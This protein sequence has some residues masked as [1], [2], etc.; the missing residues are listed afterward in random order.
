[1]SYTAVPT[2]APGD[3]VTATEFNAWVGANFAAG[4]PDIFTTKGDLAVA[5]AAD[6]AA[7]LAVGT[8]GYV[9]IADSAQATGVKWGVP[10]ICAAR[11]KNN[12]TQEIASG[13]ATD[14]IVQYDASVFDSD[15]AVTTGASW[16]FTVPTGKGGYYI[17]SASAT[18]TSTSGWGVGEKAYLRLYKNNSADA[19]LCVRNMNTNGTFSV[20][21]GGAA[22][23]SLAAGDYI[24]V[25]IYQDNDAAI[26]ITNDGDSN[27]IA[28]A[29]LF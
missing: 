2:Q 14:E 23:I 21:L 28:I 10:T 24:D 17:V 20:W 29:R 11:Y 7:R 5:T 13:A 9:L 1:M 26:N 12:A 6:T 25:R 4:V 15:S 18:L 8:N 27:H 22:V 3:E 19:Y 16:K